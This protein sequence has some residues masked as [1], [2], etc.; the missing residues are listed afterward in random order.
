MHGGVG[1][2][3]PSP[4]RVASPTGLVALHSP[5]T[6][7]ASSCSRTPSHRTNIVRSCSNTASSAGSQVVELKSPAGS[8]D[9]GGKD[10]KSTSQ[11][12]S[13]TNQEG[14]PALEMKPLEMGNAKMVGTLILKAP[15]AVIRKLKD[16]AVILES[17]ALRAVPS[18]WKPMVRFWP[19]DASMKED[20]AND[21]NSSCLPSWPDADNKDSE[22]EWKCQQCKDTQLL[23]KN[24]GT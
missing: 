16:P 4:N 5:M 11:D 2:N 14:R 24:F 7:P 22:E 8:G 21:S 10:S 6:L 3:E 19:R 23:D 13:K 1:S 20:K 18:P 9:E 15:V 17:Q 12:G